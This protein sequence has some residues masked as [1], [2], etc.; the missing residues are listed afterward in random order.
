M[1]ECVHAYVSLEMYVCMHMYECVQQHTTNEAETD[2]MA[3][4]CGD[5]M[6]DK[7]VINVKLNNPVTY[8]TKRPT[9]KWP[10]KRTDGRT[11][12]RMDRGMIEQTV[13]GRATDTLLIPMMNDNDVRGQCNELIRGL[14]Y[15]YYIFLV[16]FLL[17]A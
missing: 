10:Y 2:V 5:R 7:D 6:S 11:D 1:Y 13:V 16:Q 8:T 4:H 3:L 12:V 14:Y 9:V 17:L 15:A